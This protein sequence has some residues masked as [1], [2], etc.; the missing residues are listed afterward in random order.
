MTTNLKIFGVL[1]YEKCDWRWFT[2][3]QNG[4][5]RISKMATGDHFEK[6]DQKCTYLSEMVRNVIKVI[7][8]HPKWPPEVIL[9]TNL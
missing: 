5:N 9:W 1:L 8:G 2:V 4:P 7:F 3:I 6:N